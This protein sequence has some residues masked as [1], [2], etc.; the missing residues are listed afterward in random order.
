MIKNYYYIDSISSPEEQAQSQDNE[1]S[2]QTRLRLLPFL[3]D[4]NKLPQPA[5]SGWPDSLYIYLPQTNKDL[6]TGSY[7]WTRQHV[8]NGETIEDVHSMPE[9]RLAVQDTV[10]QLVGRKMGQSHTKC[11]LKDSLILHV[12]DVGQGDMLVLQLPDG[13][14]WV[15]DSYENRSK[16]ISSV[17]KLHSVVPNR[18]IHRAF[19]THAHEDHA[20]GFYSLLETEVIQEMIVTEAL[21]GFLPEYWVIKKAKERGIRCSVWRSGRTEPHSSVFV[22]GTCDKRHSN[23]PND[24]SLLLTLSYQNHLLVL[25]GDLPAS[26]AGER[27]ISQVEQAIGLQPG[28]SIMYKASHHGS[29]YAEHERLMLG[30]EQVNT[31]ISCG[32]TGATRYG[33]PSSDVIAN[34]A[35]KGPHW[36]TDVC[37]DIVATFSPNEEIVFDAINCSKIKQGHQWCQG[38][39]NMDPCTRNSSRNKNGCSR[40]CWE[41][42]GPQTCWAYCK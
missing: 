31:V 4:E 33:H 7:F 3:L 18:Y 12:L 16:G 26:N 1:Y 20:K 42:E 39:F 9:L 13:E 37:G 29:K 32:E 8:Q 27:V 14:N 21:E 40:Q 15:I 35:R 11:E 17:D 22:L 41:L 19:L 34:L 24:H 25:P 10:K 30:A 28:R 36:R 2:S 23:N 38:P 6:E 5:E